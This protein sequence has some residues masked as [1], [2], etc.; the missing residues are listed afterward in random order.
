MTDATDPSTP[1]PGDGA[2][3]EIE[4]SYLLRGM[5]PLPAHLPVTALRIAQGYLPDD[6]QRTLGVEG[7]IRSIHRPDGRVEHVHTVKTGS[8][9]VRTEIERPLSEAEFQRLWP[10]TAGRRLSKTRFA[11]A[12]GA[13]T[14]EIDRFDDLDLVLAEVELPSADFAVTLP[15]WLAPHVVRDVTEEPAYRNFEIALRV[16]VR[17]GGR[18]ATEPE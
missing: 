4:R 5:P 10:A 8:G 18:P 16:H 1:P 7:R 9:L 3:L 13:L 15:P 2:P 14:W 11:V 6:A 12:D 17:R